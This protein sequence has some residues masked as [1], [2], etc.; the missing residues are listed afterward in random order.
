MTLQFGFQHFQ[1]IVLVSGMSTQQ[2]QFAVLRYCTLL[3]LMS[4]TSHTVASSVLVHRVTFL[5]SRASIFNG[6][7]NLSVYDLVL[8]LVSLIRTCCNVFS[9]FT[10]TQKRL[11][12]DS[13]SLLDLLLLLSFE[14]LLF[15]DAFCFAFLM[16]SVIRPR[17]LT[18]RVQA[19]LLSERRDEEIEGERERVDTQ[20]RKK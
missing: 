4:Y 8:H 11:L 3:T 12:Y 6:Q 1:N 9:H 13:S 10:C 16:R 20:T 14:V 17:V 2:P 5:F 19:H 18:S 15:F 7:R